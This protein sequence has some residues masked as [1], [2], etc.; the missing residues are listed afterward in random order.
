MKDFKVKEF[1]AP[2]GV[3]LDSDTQKLFGAMQGWLQETFAE[4]AASEKSAE[5]YAKDISEKLEKAGFSVE[6]LSQ[7]EKALKAQGETLEKMRMGGT[8]AS[9]SQNPIR[10]AIMDNHDM[11]V[12]AFSE[13]TPF[14][15]KMPVNKDAGVITTTT[16]VTSTTSAQ[17]RGYTERDPE[18]YYKRRGR[19]YIRD[20]ADIRRVNRVPTT[21]EFW[22]E[23]AENGAF[24]VVAENALKPLVDVSLVLNQSKKQKAAG[25]MT[26]TQEVIMDSDELALN[27]ERLFVDKMWR[28]YEDKLTDSLIANATSYTS[29]SLDGTIAGPNDFDAI[30]AAALQVASLNFNPTDLILNTSDAYAMSL[31]KDSMGRYILP[32]VTEGGQLSIR[33][34]RVTT[35]T[36]LAQGEFLVGE[37][38]TW[39]VREGEELI[40]SGLNED[41]FK[42]NR[43]SF[44]GEIFFNSYIPTNYAGSWVKGN[45]AT[46]KEALKVASAPSV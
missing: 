32:I 37:Y 1:A 22:E 12:K 29:T 35:T 14:V 10:K 27:L 9:M 13:H 24:A 11:I 21:L 16:A 8:G 33:S 7:I 2:A 30:S 4:F 25:M 34:L 6:S 23:G 17:W 39:K 19:Q 41:D 5:D 40:R 42:Y 3:P 44:I 15:I 46:I 26:L 36:K 38:G 45:F 18:F 43:M 28:D 20:I 31:I